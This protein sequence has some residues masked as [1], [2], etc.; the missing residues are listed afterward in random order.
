[1]AL[2]DLRI[3]SQTKLHR[4]TKSSSKKSFVSCSSERVMMMMESRSFGQP[5]PSPARDTHKCTVLYSSMECNIDDE[6]GGG[7]EA[8]ASESNGPVA[9]EHV[10]EGVVGAGLAP[11]LAQPGGHQRREARFAPGALGGAR[12]LLPVVTWRWLSGRGRG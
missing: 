7:E 6:G 1:M 9:A 3:H 12:E 10:D 2:H 11:E 4:P 8:A 5:A